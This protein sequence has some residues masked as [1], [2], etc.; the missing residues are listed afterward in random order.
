M[1]TIAAPIADLLMGLAKASA[2]AGARKLEASSLRVA[3]GALVLEIAH[4]ALSDVEVEPD[5]L[6][7]G[8]AELSGLKLSGP[9]VL[10]QGCGSERP[11][12]AWNLAP[13]S[14]AVGTLRAE[15][16]DAHLVFDADVTVPIRHGRI[17]F[18]DATVEHVGPD[19]RMGASH[20]GLYVDAP[21]GRSYLYQF[22][23]ALVPGVE[24]E[25]RGAL[26]GPWVTDR[27]RLHLQPFA[28][29]LLCQGWGGQAL[30][31]PE[32]ARGLFDRAAVSGE[33][34]LGEGQLAAPGVQAV[35]AGRNGVRLHSEAVGRSLTVELPTLAVAEAS[36]Q[37]LG[38]R[39]ACKEL[40][41]AV[42]LRVF[43]EGAQM[44]FALEIASLGAS[45]LAIS[46][47]RSSPP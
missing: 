23:S 34:E 3:H 36:V 26:L 10:P 24:F 27:G 7:A 46:P 13:L 41:A 4:L 1:G 32:Q 22:P 45:G 30:A 11:A 31:F 33:V 2:S 25:T 38:M 6:R 21:N 9:L 40:A 19:S 14:A 17:D 8:R 20:L 28:E 15:I 18:K 35:L 42:R 43:T 29:W 37:A 5:G 47:W 16:V 44:R 12:S 39:L